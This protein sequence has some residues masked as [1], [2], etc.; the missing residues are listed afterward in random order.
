MRRNRARARSRIRAPSPQLRPAPSR[1]RT[2]FLDTARRM[3]SHLRAKLDGLLV[4]LRD[5]HAVR[6]LVVAGV[7]LA[8]F[9]LYV[10]F[11]RVPPQE[12]P[13]KFRWDAPEE[14]E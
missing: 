10:R 5:V 13:A 8:L 11:V 6:T 9:W 7:P 12:R 4:P 3:L 14:A 1:L 2:S